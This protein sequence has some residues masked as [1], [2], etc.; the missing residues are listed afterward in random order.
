MA[1]N[2]IPPL[3]EGFTL[4]QPQAQPAPVVA[5]T[6][7]PTP[8]Q[9]PPPEGFTVD[10]PTGIADIG[11]NA[12]WLDVLTT[13]AQNIP[14]SAINFG[15][16]IVQVVENPRESIN[17][18]A[19]LFFGLQEKLVPGES[20]TPEQQAREEKA[21]LAEAMRDGDSHQLSAL[22]RVGNSYRTRL[23]AQLEIEKAKRRNRT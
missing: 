10:A 13:A 5:P 7:S 2:I 20:V 16:D 15:K 8:Q 12:A 11:D 18:I 19:G 14:G 17:Q 4:D 6:P 21:D 22:A 23:S 9:I 1:N 3:P